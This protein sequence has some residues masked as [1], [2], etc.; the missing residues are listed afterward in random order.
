MLWDGVLLKAD[1]VL[2]F[3]L[4]VDK[5]QVPNKG[6]L[7]LIFQL[8]QQQSVYTPSLFKIPTVLFLQKLMVCTVHQK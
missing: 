3:L 7:F 8:S 4:C 1:V 6:H 5:Q 2:L